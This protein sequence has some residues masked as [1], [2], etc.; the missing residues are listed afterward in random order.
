MQK[1]RLLDLRKELLANIETSRKNKC[2]GLNGDKSDGHWEAGRG[3]ALGTE[4]PD[5]AWDPKGK[6]RKS[7]CEFGTE[8]WYSRRVGY[9][10]VWLGQETQ[11][12]GSSE[13]TTRA[14]IP[15]WAMAMT[16]P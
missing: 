5:A 9:M 2:D 15:G 4:V 14:S 8:P 3:T 13:L 12:S 16:L 1:V 6:S 10:A 7:C 11:A